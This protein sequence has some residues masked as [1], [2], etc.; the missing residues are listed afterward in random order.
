MQRQSLRW[1]LAADPEALSCVLFQVSSY[2]WQ[3]PG[4][5]HCQRSLDEPV[6]LQKEFLAE[7]MQASLRLYTGATPMQV[8]AI[9]APAHHTPD[10]VQATAAAAEADKDDEPAAWSVQPKHASDKHG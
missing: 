4:L 9:Y 8:Y 1:L 5:R 3:P 7:Q 10:K 2:R 6:D